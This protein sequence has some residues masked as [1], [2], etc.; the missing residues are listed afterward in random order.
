MP[1][2]ATGI[3]AFVIIIV[4][5]YHILRDNKVLTNNMICDKMKVQVN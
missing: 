4:K 1:Q 2:P 3:I 5:L